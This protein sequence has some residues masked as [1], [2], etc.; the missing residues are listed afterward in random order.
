M[1]GLLTPQAA[2][3]VPAQGNRGAG[4]GAR[5][6]RQMGLGMDANHA[7]FDSAGYSAAWKSRSR[8]EVGAFAWSLLSTIRSVVLGCS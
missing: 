2:P 4:C 8:K 6:H 1:S 7:Y 3:V 5:R